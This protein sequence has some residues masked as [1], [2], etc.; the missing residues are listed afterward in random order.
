[1]GGALKLLSTLTLVVVVALVSFTVGA[2]ADCDPSDPDGHGGALSQTGREEIPTRAAR[3]Y[4][5]IAKRWNIDVAFLASIGAQ[6]CDHGRCPTIRQV[7]WAGCVGW[8]QLGVG[9]KCGTYWQRNQ[10]DGNRDGQT[11]VLDPW[12]NICAAAKGLRKEKGAPPTGG[13][14]A[15]Y[16]QAAGRYYGACS[17]NGVAYCDQVMDRAR[18]YGFRPG[19]PTTQL[20][21][22]DT[23]PPTGE[24]CD[25]DDSQLASLADGPGRDFDLV[26]NANRPGVPLTPD[27]VR[28][29]RQIA[30]RLPRRLKVCT[31]TNHNRRST[32]GNVSDHWSGNAVDL[33]SS[34]N[35]FPATGGGYGDQVATAALM[36]AGKPRAEA[37]RMARQGGAFTIVHASL[38]F[39]II[40]KSTVGGNHFDHVHIGIA[41]LP[42]RPT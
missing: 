39:Q 2:P 7:N 4:E 8:M 15:A 31:G 20:A 11:D 32:S 14:E 16:R 38:R 41:R 27:M 30:G 5:A 34:A 25:A 36:V 37:A 17:G 19:Q 18:R 40:W 29:T 42:C 28:V 12:D 33:C 26:P 3:M 35:G 13:S 24:R 6:E 9:G 22:V 21:S 10:C 23:A 1:M